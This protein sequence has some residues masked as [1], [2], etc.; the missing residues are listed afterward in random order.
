LPTPASRRA[1]AAYWQRSP[2]PFERRGDRRAAQPRRSQTPDAEARGRDAGRRPLSPS[3][4]PVRGPSRGRE[5]PRLLSRSPPR[6]RHSERPEL[7][8]RARSRSH[9]SDF[10]RRRRSRSRSPTPLSRYRSRSPVRHLDRRRRSPAPSPSRS[11]TR[12]DLHRDDT[13]LHGRGEWGHLRRPPSHQQRRSRWA[14]RSPSRPRWQ[15]EDDDDDS[16]RRRFRRRS[17]S[18]LR[19]QR[20][21]RSVS[22][23]AV[24]RSVSRSLSPSASMS[25]SPR[26]RP[27]GTRSPSPRFARAARPSA[28][29]E[30]ARRRPPLSP[31]RPRASRSP[32]MSPRRHGTRSPVRAL[33][34]EARLAHLREAARRRLSRSPSP[35]ERRDTRRPL[36]PRCSHSRSPRR[37][38]GGARAAALE[39][40]A[41]PSCQPATPQERGQG[42]GAPARDVAGRDR[43]STMAGVRERAS[44]QRSRPASG[45][46]GVE[47]APASHAP[48]RPLGN[49]L[50]PVARGA[51]DSDMEARLD[52]LKSAVLKTRPARPSSAIDDVVIPHRRPNLGAAAVNTAPVLTPGG[53]LGGSA[54]SGK[55]DGR[56]AREAPNNLDAAAA[57]GDASIPAEAPTDGREGG[58]VTVGVEQSKPPGAPQGIQSRT[59]GPNRASPGRAGDSACVGRADVVDGISIVGKPAEVKSASEAMTTPKQVRKDEALAERSEASLGAPPATAAE[60]ELM[61]VELSAGADR[62]EAPAAVVEEGAPDGDVVAD[63]AVK[64]RS[65]SKKGAKQRGRKDTANAERSVEDVDTGP[66]VKVEVEPK[67]AR[68]LSRS[69]ARAARGTGDS[70]AHV[71]DGEAKSARSRKPAPRTGRASTRKTRSVPSDTRNK[72]SA[73]V[74]G[75]SDGQGTETSRPPSRNDEGGKK[76]D[77]ERAEAT[78]AGSARALRP[79]NKRVAT[80]DLIADG[81]EPATAGSAPSP[82]PKRRRTRRGT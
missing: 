6:R 67:P 15:R 37:D 58:P 7:Y 17:P 5:R 61:A 63:R 75:G 73:T 64:V 74:D 77:A 56:P 12:R 22:P 49:T 28:L 78:G 81:N 23:A 8:S 66:E 14:P 34:G 4:S 19:A 55:G 33:V 79:R 27:R 42:E 39:Q 45:E 41:G 1:D 51:A 26:R 82:A 68:R 3:V 80:G 24:S 40:A 65:A 59:S 50:R 76:V 43:G 36:S 54:T 46:G 60:G 72:S 62:S 20:V 32:S 35:H 10:E 38:L 57:T 71:A 16:V 47:C 48:A 13:S 11:P 70:T 53:T 69:A 52:L 31:P 30:A 29:R 21:S 9:S 44:I 18:P 2:S 25:P